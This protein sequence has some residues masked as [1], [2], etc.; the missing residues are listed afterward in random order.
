MKNILNSRF[1]KNASIYTLSD[2]LNKLIPFILLPVLTRYLTPEDYGIIA[3]FFVFTSVLSI[4]MTLETQTSIQV[5]Y[6]KISRDRIKIYIANSLLIVA[7]AT[8]LT[9]IMILLFHTQISMLLAIPTEW[10]FVGVVVT[11]SQFITTINLLLWQSEHNPLPLGIY[12]I[13]Q[14]IFNLSL[15]LILIISFG[16][17]WEGRLIAISIAS[18]GFGILSFI[19]LFKRDY[20]QFTINNSDI[21]DAMKFGIPL[22]PHA[23]SSWFRTGVD[24]ILITTLVSA[25][26]TG[27]YTVAFQIAF[28]I[29]ILVKSFNKAYSPY[30]FEKLKDIK[31]KDK[32]IIVKYTYLY[33]IALLLLAGG[34]TLITPFLID[35]FLGKNFLDSKKY[36]PWITFSFAFNG[37]Y[38]MIVNYVLFTKK[39]ASL[40]YVTISVSLFHVIISYLLISYNGI[41]GAAQATTVT[42]FIVFLAVWRL[43]QKIYPMPWFKWFNIKGITH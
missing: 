33:F 39:T 27:L 26:A 14:T 36:I 38:L 2:I 12:Q 29:M 32:G 31:E 21:K 24:R 28:I 41:L 17:G 15:T 5:N 11:L 20:L 16:M 9:C 40:S 22:L 23:I 7:L 19:F 34:L 3:M 10:I 13:S 8:S 18:I 42:S 30:L 43:S 6:F 4:V 35:G 37:M 1:F 25:A